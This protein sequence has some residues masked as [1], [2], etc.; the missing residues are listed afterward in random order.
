VAPRVGSARQ[1]HTGAGA[2]A[3]AGGSSGKGRTGD[4]SWRPE[5]PE[6]RVHPETQSFLGGR[7]RS[8][9]CQHLPGGK[10][11]PLRATKR[12]QPTAGPIHDSHGGPPEPWP[13]H[14]SPALP[15]KHQARSS[16]GGGGG[17]IWS[18][19]GRGAGGGGARWP[20]W[21]RG[22]PPRERELAG[23]ALSRFAHTGRGTG[24]SE[25]P[26]GDLASMSIKKQEGRTVSAAPPTRRAG[27]DQG[28]R[29]GGTQT[30]LDGA[31]R[32]ARAGPHLLTGIQGG[33]EG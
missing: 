18:T 20:K 5:G 6:P 27:P 19:G 29:P 10:K 30:V 16:R 23:G 26:N 4:Q 17:V 22:H 32:T 12:Q 9:P 15:H 3:Q 31:P 33:G 11:G 25:S 2:Q 24:P 8:R 7:H 21:G 28:P 13:G 1:H 14:L